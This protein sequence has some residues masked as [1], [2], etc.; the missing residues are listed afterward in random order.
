MPQSILV[1]DDDADTLT[2]IGLTLQRRGF[3]VIKAQSG[4][5]AMG[6][7]SHDLPDL[8]VLD[9][10]MPH[11]DGYEVCREIKAD[12]RTANLPI[13]MLTAKAQTS[14]QLEGFRAGAIDYITKPVHPQDLVA[15][16][17]AVLDRTRPAPVESTARLIAV[18]GAKGGVGATTLAV[19]LAVALAAHK[20]TILVDL[21]MSGSAALH[22]GLASAPGLNE[23]IGYEG[24]PIEPKM[25]AQML[26]SHA[27]GLQLLAAADSPIDPARATLIINH[28]LS[29]CEVLILDLGWGMG[30]TVRTLAPRC[31]S[32]ILATDA[33]RASLTQANRLWHMLTEVG[34]APEAIQLVWVNR[35]GTPDGTATAAIQSV[36]G[37]PPVATVGPAADTMY[38]ALENGQPLVAAVP[39][40]TVSREITALADSLLP[41]G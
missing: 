29:Q 21:E 20:R 13:V 5:Q 18:S 25:V 24:D 2:L 33:D 38:T 4:Q 17:Q 31:Q 39:E 3:E 32:F 41:T 6:L 16:I 1:V 8:V 26:Q 27:S 23:L 19:N 28:L 40:H 37:Q 11:M 36:L 30:Q 10:M 22:L 14:S 7:L 35:Q 9:V 15:R 34:T 12:P